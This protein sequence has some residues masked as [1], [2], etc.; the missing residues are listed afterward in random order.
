MPLCNRRAIG[1]EQT[2]PGVPKNELFHSRN[3][4]LS[5]A[6]SHE[7]SSRVSRVGPNKSAP[8]S[9]VAAAESNASRVLLFLPPWSVTTDDDLLHEG[10]GPAAGPATTGT[11]GAA[12][13]ARLS[14]GHHGD[15]EQTPAWPP[16]PPSP[17]RPRKLKRLRD[18]CSPPLH[19]GLSVAADTVLRGAA[20]VEGEDSSRPLIMGKSRL[21]RAASAQVAPLPSASFIG[22]SSRPV[23]LPAVAILLLSVVV[24]VS[25]LQLLLLQLLLLQLLLPPSSGGPSSLT[26]PRPRCRGKNGGPSRIAVAATAAAAAGAEPKPNAGLE[27]PTA[28][29]AASA[30]MG[31]RGHVSAPPPSRLPAVAAGPGASELHDNGEARGTVLGDGTRR[32][33]G[34]GLCRCPGEKDRGRSL[35]HW[36]WW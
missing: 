23:L 3:P 13:T 1:R 5:L 9:S 18:L 22:E 21:C 36:R 4:P 16:P 30:T 12:A 19:C 14:D 29:S 26:P 25:L 24:G 31:A 10:V 33:G 34:G 32:A 28:A 35:L 11:G 27:E 20:A 8:W 2:Q 15:D 17:V 7:T 6:R